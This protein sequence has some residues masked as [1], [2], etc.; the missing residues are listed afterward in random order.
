MCFQYKK[1][2]G[3]FLSSVEIFT[4][5]ILNIFVLQLHN[6][7]AFNWCILWRDNI[8]FTAKRNQQTSN[9]LFL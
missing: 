6:P 5:F 1:Q 7:K 2:G 3:R 9:H 4:H 8:V